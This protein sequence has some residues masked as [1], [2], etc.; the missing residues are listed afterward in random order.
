[1]RVVGQSGRWLKINRGGNEVWLADWVNYSRI[2]GSEPTGSQQPAAPIDNCCFVD[3]LCQSNQ[4]WVDGYWAYQNGQC[5]A[6]TQPQPATPAQPVASTPATVN[7]CCFVDRQCR[8]D[9]E[10]VSGYWAYQNGQC[11][12][13]AQP[14]A[15]TTVVDWPPT[16]GNCCSVNWHCRFDEERVQG[17]MAFQLFQCADPTQTSAITLTGPVPRIEGSD[18]FVRHIVATLKLMKSL[19]PDWYNY[20]ITGMDVIVEQPVHLPPGYY[21]GQY[22][23]CTARAHTGQRKASLETCWIDLSSRITGNIVHDQADTAAALGHEACHLHL[24]AEG[25]KFP[26][27]EREEEECRK[28]GTGAGTLIDSA[29]AAGLNPRRGTTYF[30]KDRALSLL[31]TYCSQGYRADLFCSTLQKLESEWA[32]V[33]YAVFPPGAP[34]W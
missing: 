28:F 22:W 23:A 30:K 25:I 5:A 26:S 14:Q 9:E 16:G 20:V 12:A 15:A 21:D 8:T 10:W 11:G 1:M 7:N 13:P 29:L 18:R 27:S 33:P 31:R 2:E 3:R 4:E 24:H 34:E 17:F 32:N 19:A 6:P